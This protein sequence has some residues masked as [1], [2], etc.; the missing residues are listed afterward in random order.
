MYK[1]LSSA[2]KIS[3]INRVLQGESVSK[4]CR[5]AGIS[6]TIFYRWLAEYKKTKL[7]QSLLEHRRPRGQSHWRHVSGL[8]EL[9]LQIVMEYPHF[10]AQRITDEINKMS[11]KTEVSTYTTYM[12]LKRFDLTT[13]QK[14]IK[15]VASKKEPQ[16]VTKKISQNLDD[17][18]RVSKHS[19]ARAMGAILPQVVGSCITLAVFF[20]IAYHSSNKFGIPWWF[21]NSPLDQISQKN[22]KIAK[23]TK[24]VPQNP[25]QA[26]FL[27][28]AN[29]KWG[30]LAVNTNKSRYLPHE[31]VKVSFGVLDNVG[32]TICNA[33]L[34]LKIIR[35]TGKDDLLSVKNGSI[36]LLPDCWGN[37]GTTHSDYIT[38]YEAREIGRYEMELIA[39]TE[40]GS[41]AGKRSFLVLDSL[42]FS[43]QRTGPSRIYPPTLYP[44]VYRVRSYRDFEGTIS[45]MIPDDFQISR[46][47]TVLGYRAIQSMG[48]SKMVSWHVSL[49]KGEEVALGYEFKAPYT[50]PQLY[51]LGP[52]QFREPQFAFVDE[53][54]W[55][56]A[57]DAIMTHNF[58]NVASASAK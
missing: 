43:I 48:E 16:A 13:P 53:S 22:D 31:K 35:P 40:N 55:Q 18:M 42:P 38:S 32:G 21:N 44:M 56:I 24:V 14:R 45:Q 9:V 7:S 26:D 28:E 15:H 54:G 20:L 36:T 5:E 10:S 52:L 1:S 27:Q 57:S 19:S 25:P 51:T 50:S 47:P 39:E 46:L 4:V 37:K 33:N 2:E 29:F 8:E 30:V 58:S 23:D 6:R 17:L 3:L 12:L 41:Y 34:I 11:P 49:K